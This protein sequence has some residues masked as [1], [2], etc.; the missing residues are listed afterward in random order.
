[1]RLA[2]PRKRHRWDYGGATPYICRRKTCTVCG[3][4]GSTFGVGAGRYW[5]YETKDGILLRGTR[6]PACPPSETS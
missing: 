2:V 4:T 1:M 6:Q 3:V 5:T